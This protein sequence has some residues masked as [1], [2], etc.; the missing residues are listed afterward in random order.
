MGNNLRW[1][2]EDVEDVY[3]RRRQA[4]LDRPATTAKVGKA[5]GQPRFDAFLGLLEAHG[6][7]KPETE[8]RFLQDRQFR[9]DY[10]WPALKIIVERQGGLFSKGD[11]AKKAHGMALGILRDY[12]KSNLAQAAGFQYYQFTPEQLEKGPAVDF[13]KVLLR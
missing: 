11:R 5:E 10:C 3:R 2:A 8:Y 7:P 1:R 4:P 13:L 12:E 6:L 9:A